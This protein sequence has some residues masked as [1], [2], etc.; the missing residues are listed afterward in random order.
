VQLRSVADRIVGT[1]Y[2]QIVLLPGCAWYHTAKN[3][4]SEELE[5]IVDNVQSG[6]HKWLREELNWNCPKSDIGMTGGQR[7]TLFMVLQSDEAAKL[8]VDDWQLIKRIENV[9][10]CKIRVTRE[11]AEGKKLVAAIGPRNQLREV[12]RK[13]ERCIDEG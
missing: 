3:H 6:L 11:G 7:R 5:E 8:M 2:S 13:I 1:T 9:T 12:K 4:S 10:G